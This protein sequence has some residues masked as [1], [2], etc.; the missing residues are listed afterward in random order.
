MVREQSSSP[1]GRDDV[2]QVFSDV[3]GTRIVFVNLLCAVLVIAVLIGLGLVVQGIYV[4]PDLP[5]WNYSTALAPIIVD[6]GRAPR[7]SASSS[8]GVIGR[9]LPNSANSTTRLAF[10]A[11][12]D[13]GSFE[14][15]QR[16]AAKIDKLLPDW[17]E[18]GADG[19]LSNIKRSEL[20]VRTWLAS[21]QDTLGII[22][23]LSSALPRSEMVALLS[24]PPHRARLTSALANYLSRNN[25]HGIAVSL[26]G[27]PGMVLTQFISDLVENVRPSG[28]KIVV[29]FESPAEAWMQPIGR[30]ADYVLVK[31]YSQSFWENHQTAAVPQLSLE[32]QVTAFRALIPPSKL[33]IGL[34]SFAVDT[35]PGAAARILSVQR[36]WD[37]LGE[38][39]AQLSL[40]Q[41]LQISSFRYVEDSGAAHSVWIL[42]GVS[43]F[44]QLRSV[45]LHQPAG[46][47]LWR[48]GFEDPS[49][50]ASFGRGRL[51]DHRALSGLA[52]LQP[53]PMTLADGLELISSVDPPKSGRRSIEYNA[54]TG[55]IAGQSVEPPFAAR[56]AAITQSDDR[57]I[58]LTFDDGPHETVT[59]RILDILQMRSIRGTFF[60]LGSNAM[61]NPSVLRRTFAE[62]HDIGNHTYTHPDLTGLSTR[63]FGA[64]LNA[65]QRMLEAELGIHTTLFRPPF[66]GASPFEVAGAHRVIEGAS[67]LGYVTVLSGVDSG[68]WLNLT[69]EAL[70]D[71]VVSKVIAARGKIVLFHDWG[72]RQ[73]T[74]DALPVVIDALASRGYRFVTI[75]ELMG[76]A[77]EEVMP[78]V[79]AD[80][81][82]TRATLDVRAWAVRALGWLGRALPA[83]AVLGSVLCIGRLIFVLISVRKHQRAEIARA[84]LAAKPRS[85][86]VII[87]AFNEERVI[88][89]TVQSVL[90]P[91]DCYEIIVVDDGSSDRTAQVVQETFRA[92]PRVRVFKKSN[93][94][95]AAAANFGLVRTDAE[96]IIAIDADTVLAPNAI[97][98][99]VRHFADP[100]VGAVAGTA[101][102][103]NQVN[104]LTRMQALEYTIGQSLDRRAFALYNANGIVPGAIGAW[105][106][107][108][109]LQVGGYASD[110][111]AEDADITFSVIRAGWKVLYE[112]GAIARTEAP[113]NYRSFLK[114][115]Y[116]WM[117]GML[118]VISKHTRAIRQRT[119]LGLLAISNVVIFQFGFSVLV[120]ILDLVCVWQLGQAL[121]HYLVRD[122]FF[123]TSGMAT[124]AKWWLLF[125][126]LD[127][128]ALA[129]ALKIGGLKN[130]WNCIPLL[131]TQRFC[132]WPLIYWTALATML[133]AAKGRVVGWNKLNR[134]GRVSLARI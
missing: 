100:A 74:L 33:I 47:A 103:G 57:L 78:P 61:Q 87:P 133:A 25:D 21:S 96:V 31:L 14:A 127:L 92:D 45:L 84:R 19:L 105:R 81:L 8:S 32:S 18:I 39:G 83:L 63:E 4:A 85:V 86:A 77:R 42:D 89:K 91:W 52:D 101:M 34:A 46:I 113:E 29:I 64:E 130:A 41:N 69:A 99:L 49:V 53:G 66:I 116:R 51:P 9:E 17:L 50:W 106:R 6:G 109:V 124:Y 67:S 56:A 68:D 1:Q 36:A 114:Q 128:L 55:L 43:I 70:V 22:P 54:R 26:P 118:Q 125:Q 16:Y 126:L 90:L 131:L 82:L 65:T 73:A 95:K 5:K 3:S 59:D 120:P 88:C 38:S 7:T 23:V 20:R 48:L 132:Y 117:F 134:T 97:P 121:W 60:I 44:N 79:V 12:D 35:G 93:G 11:A 76:K 58:A 122:D 115:R 28:R 129:A 107:D 80:T 98:L 94:G 123:T 24:S 15:L 37:L 27:T 71:R 111:V 75:H 62:G 30:I 40:H 13:S 104:L 110:T 119:A 2:R 108:A 102:V 112:P 10:L 72:K